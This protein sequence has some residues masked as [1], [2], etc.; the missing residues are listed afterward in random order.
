MTSEQGEDERGEWMS[1][2]SKS[3]EQRAIKQTARTDTVYFTY[4]YYA[5]DIIH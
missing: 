3:W 4:L 5:K 2:D 1:P